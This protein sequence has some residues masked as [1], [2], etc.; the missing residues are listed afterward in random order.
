[1][2]DSGVV[3]LAATEKTWV[4]VSTNGKT[5]FAGVLEPAETRQFHGVENGKLVTGNAAGIDVEWNG[6]AIGPIGPRGQVRTVLLSGESFQILT[7]SVSR[8]M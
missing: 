1:M 7:P 6:K 3:K 5:L 4:S 8:R 2:G